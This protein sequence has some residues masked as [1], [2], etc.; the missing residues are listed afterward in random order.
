MRPVTALVL[1]VLVVVFGA[2]AVF[3]LGG[4]GAPDGELTERWISDTPRNNSI[5]HHAVGVGPNGDVIVA[6]VATIAANNSLLSPTSCTLAR[7]SPRDGAVRWRTTVPPADCFMH[8]L[9]EPAIADVDGDSS[10][11]VV[12]ATIQNATVVYAAESGD[13]ETRIPLSTYGYG[14]PTVANV[15]DA[16]GPEIVTSDINGYVVVAGGDGTVH[17]TRSLN[18]TT[19]AAPAVADIDDDG[20]QEVVV[21]RNDRTVAL[22][23]DGSLAW[24]TDVPGPNV[25]IGQADEDAALEIV[26]ASGDGVTALDGRDGSIEW[27]HT[28]EGGATLSAHAVGDGNGDGATEVYYSQPGNL[29]GAL[30]ADSG[31]SEWTTRLAPEE[32]TMTPAPVLGDLTGDQTRELVTVTNGG[33]VTVLD[34]ETGSQL[35]VYQHDIPVWTFPTV[36]DV[37]DDPGSEILVRYGDG[38]VAALAYTESP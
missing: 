8:A 9:T 14:R 30:R 3:V 10:L 38:R 37:T 18:D 1:A 17:W 22:N 23:A 15:T 12:A 5:N 25:A 21:G 16:Q 35:A 29:V 2:T 28:V 6:P 36:A 31:Q 19:W 27:E 32:N 7:L 20:S 26:T 4:N 33:T 34:P 11:E 13:V 24:E